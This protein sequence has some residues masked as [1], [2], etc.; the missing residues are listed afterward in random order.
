MKKFYNF[1]KVSKKLRLL[2]VLEILL[3]TVSFILILF[4]Y[5]QNYTTQQSN[6][7]YHM[8]QSLLIQT[9]SV[10]EKMDNSLDFPLAHIADRYDDPLL[11]YLIEHDHGDISETDFYRVF[12]MRVSE[13]SIQIPDLESLFLFDTDGNLLNGK[14][15][16]NRYIPLKNY[17]DGRWYQNTI[18]EAG[19][20][21]ILRKE[22]IEYFG[23]RNTSKNIYGARLLYDYL[24]LKPICMTLMS[25]RATDIPVTF[26]TTKEFSEQQY[27]LF[28]SSGQKLIGNM[29][30]SITKDNLSRSSRGDYHFSRKEDDGNS[31]LYHV[32]YSSESGGLYSVIRTPY[33][34]FIRNQLRAVCIFMIAG[35]LL[36]VLN[37][38][39]FTAIIRSIN[40]PLSRM[41]N[42][43][44]EM[45]KGNFSI[46]IPCS[47]TDELSYLMSSL[48]SMSERI[49]QLINEVYV[50]NL[51]KRDLELQMLRSQINPHFLYNTLENMRMSAY[52]QGYTDLSEMCFLLSKVLRY[53][54]SEQDKLVTVR[55]ELEQLKN[56][57]DLLHYCLPALHIFVFV[58]DQIMD[59]SIIKVILQPLVENSV[60]HASSSPDTTLTIQ[61]WGYADENDIVF[62][63]SDNGDGIEEAYLQELIQSLDAENDT[64][65][66]IGLKNIHRRI[67]LYYGPDYGL[68]LQSSPGRGTSV[69]VRIPKVQNQKE[70][71]C[72]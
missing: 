48:N 5:M 29:Q 6:T 23:L 16:Y 60:N 12:A 14:I 28:D 47:Q 42:M 39:I 25:I 56:Y 18:Q 7:I 54:V 11:R 41:I 67:R 21:H 1:Y 20:I 13:V 58:D 10:I 40:Q 72:L 52:T 27:A 62:T 38:I 2:M 61:I 17:S 30:S 19:K 51:T 71:V 63:V 66:G 35:V 36:I 44:E 68:T 55:E 64:R 43:C 32:S 50:K 31:Y 49:E 45:G 33:R 8:N 4:F 57:T 37:I 24:T 65:H 9:N 26:E 59:Y 70:I 53:G 34:L 22:E 15:I 46:R 3:L 69:T